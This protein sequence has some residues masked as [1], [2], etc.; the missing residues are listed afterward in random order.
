MHANNGANHIDNRGLGAICHAH[1]DDSDNNDCSDN[2]T[3]SGCR[4]APH[5]GSER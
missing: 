2:C 3:I 5:R 4:A 1:L